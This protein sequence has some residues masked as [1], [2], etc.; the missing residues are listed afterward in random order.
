MENPRP[1]ETWIEFQRR[2]IPKGETCFNCPHF[3][4]SKDCGLF[5]GSGQ[6]GKVTECA[7]NPGLNRP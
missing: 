5:G 7:T 1:G 4:Y 2:I 3:Q 6:Y